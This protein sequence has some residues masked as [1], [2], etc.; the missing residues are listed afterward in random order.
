MKI[1]I[2]DNDKY[3]L[4]SKE[5]PIVGRHY[6]LED[7][8]SGTQ[9]QNKAF[10]AL[11]QEYYITGMSSYIADSLPDFKKQI[12]KYL[13]AGFESYIYVEIH[14][15]VM[16]LEEL[17]RPVIRDAKKYEDIPEEVRK[18]E[19][20][21]ELIRGK[22]KSWSDYIKKQRRST[23]SNLITEMLAAGVNT[24]KFNEIMEGLENE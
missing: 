4:E 24:G 10:H 20:Y 7:A 1:L 8:E 9:A 13:G 18:D 6:N 15:P 5:T 12:K 19:H 3:M 23:M 22:L 21:K 14:Q 16:G 11:I 2:L 17:N